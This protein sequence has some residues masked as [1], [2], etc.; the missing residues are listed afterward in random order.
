M[1]QNLL[2]PALT[3]MNQTTVTILA[4]PGSLVCCLWNTSSVGSVLPAAAEHLPVASSGPQ[5]VGC[6]A[7]G[8]PWTVG[9]AT[10]M[11]HL[12]F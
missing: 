8:E 1:Y 9:A 2:K 3:E 6:N 10:A 7:R 11:G 4:A 5:K 12:C